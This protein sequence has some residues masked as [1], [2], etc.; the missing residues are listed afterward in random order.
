MKKAF[1]NLLYILFL[2]TVFISSCSKDKVSV[3]EFDVQ[4]TGTTFKVGQPIT[5]AFS[6]S[7]DY[8]TFYSGE[9]GHKYANRS[10]TSE[11]GTAQTLKFTSAVASGT[12]ANNLA[13]MA[14]TDFNGNYTAADIA[15]ATWVDI[16]GRAKLSVGP[17]LAS[18]SISLNDFATAAKPFYL[19]FYYYAPQTALKPRNW[20]ISATSITNTLADGTVSTVIADFPS[21]GFKNVNVQDT[22]HN[23]TIGTSNMVMIGGIMGEPAT[24]AWAISTAINLSTVSA[25]DF[26][27]GIKSIDALLPNYSYTY[28]TAGTYKVTFLAANTN[29]NGSKSKVKEITINVTN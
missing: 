26:G 1:P 3:P 22:S 8:L 23:W 14:S 21:A 12:Q 10:R 18:G 29:V 16:T 20:T 4:I 13:V 15:K 17:S 24:Q 5:F 2:L 25:P 28:T 19:G 6:G 27:V 9:T 11:L 7:P